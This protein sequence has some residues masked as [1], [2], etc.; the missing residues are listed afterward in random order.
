MYIACPKC[1]ANTIVLPEQIGIYGRKVRCPRCGN[2]WHQKDERSCKVRRAY[3]IGK[4]IRVGDVGKLTRS[5]GCNDVRQDLQQDVTDDAL[6]SEVQNIF[7]PSITA[8]VLLLKD[9]SIS[10]I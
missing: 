10:T 9:K 5:R 7:P 1:D 3:N 2:I 6:L 8:G 4:E